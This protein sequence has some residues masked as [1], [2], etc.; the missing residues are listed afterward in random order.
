MSLVLRVRE[1]GL[2][3][4]APLCSSFVFP[5]SS[6]TKRKAGAFE[7]DPNYRPVLLG[8]AMVMVA[9]FLAATAVSR[10]VHFAIENPAGSTLWS[11]S[12]LF[13]DFLD[14]KAHN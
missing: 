10:E 3:W 13:T 4:M 2:V 14:R 6:R 12:R 5:D 7:G 8:N 1:G 9:I 11:F